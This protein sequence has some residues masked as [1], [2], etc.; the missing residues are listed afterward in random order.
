MPKDRC[1]GGI[2]TFA[3]ATQR[4]PTLISP[5]SG[6][7]RPAIRRSNVV[8]PQPDGP[9]RPRISPSWTQRLRS[10][11]ARKRP[12]DLCKWATWTAVF[13]VGIRESVVI[14]TQKVNCLQCSPL[15]RNTAKGVK[16]SAGKK[17]FPLRSP[18]LQ[19]R[20]LREIQAPPLRWKLFAVI[21]ATPNSG[22]KVLTCCRIL[23]IAP[24]SF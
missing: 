23:A 1:S 8:L 22:T 7:S 10:R 12:K 24:V 16:A 3:P 2:N 15:A 13:S 17:C 19:P 18:L 6:V 4:S 21:S 9:N 11:I 5:A 14:G 20:A